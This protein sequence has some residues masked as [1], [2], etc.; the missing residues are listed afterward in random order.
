[1][2]QSYRPTPRSNYPKKSFLWLLCTLPLI[3][4]SCD[5]KNTAPELLPLTELSVA[6]N[7]PVSLNIYARDQEQDQLNFS[8]NFDPLPNV[9]TE[10]E[11]GRPTLTPL[12]AQQALFQ[13]VPSVGDVGVYNLTVS[14][15]DPGGLSDEETVRLEVYS[16][17]LSQSRIRFT[18]P[19]G[20]GERLNVNAHPCLELT[21][22]VSAEGIPD[23]DLLIDL[24]DPLIEGADFS[25]SGEWVGKSRQLRWCPTPPQLE[26]SDRYTLNLSVKQKRIS[27]SSN[28]EVM[29]TWTEG[30][31]KRYLV[32]LE[33]GGD[34][35]AEGCIGRPPSIDHTPPR[36]LE[37]LDDYR[38]EIFVS[39]DLGI[40]SP[41]LLALW[42][43]A[44]AP[45][46][47]L[48]DE[49]WSLSE[50]SRSSRGEGY[51]AFDIPNLNLLM[52]E[53]ATLYYAI[54]V[55][56][57][58]DA[59]GSR[60][61][62]VTESP[63][64]RLTVL[65]GSSGGNRAVCAPCSVS[66]QCGGEA[67]LCLAYE[68]GQFCGRACDT[69]RPCVSGQECL[70]LATS[71]GEE[72]AQCVPTTLSCVG[73]CSPDQY[74]QTE[75]VSY[76][77]APSLQE[78]RYTQLQICDQPYDLYQVAVP[79][80]RGLDISLSF[81]A[82]ELDL[83]LAVS[84]GQDASGQPDFA[85]ESATPDRS[86]ERVSLSCVDPQQPVNAL[87]AVL[88][89][90]DGAQGPYQL[91]INL[92]VDGCQTPCVDDQFEGATP[93]IEDGFYANLKLC[94]GDADR[95]SFEVMDGWVIS[96]LIEYPLENGA[97]HLTLLDPQGLPVIS[98]LSSR[99]EAI[100][101][102]RAEFGGRYTLEVRGE[103]Q[104]TQNEYTL[105]LYLFPTQ[106]CFETRDCPEQRFC[107]G[108]LGCLQDE[109]TPT[110][111]CGAGHRCIYSPFVTL[112]SPDVEGICGAEC[113]LNVDCRPWEQCKV[114]L[115]AQSICV[116]EGN[117]EV[118]ARCTY[119]DECARL[120]ACTPLDG[121][122]YCLHAA[123]E[124]IGCAPGEQCISTESGA[125]CLPS[126]SPACPSG[127]SC[128]NRDGMNICQPS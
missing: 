89:Y 91:E 64:Y 40:K 25:P 7:T 47:Q 106:A 12:S 36:Q 105:D 63:I 41:P 101:E 86:T 127:W 112:S 120:L 98:D 77:D 78:G 8:F 100:V 46:V 29:T 45:P 74:D 51:W 113:A 35:P 6:V 61:D 22:S 33:R 49:G 30:A 14:V 110:L 121:V 39:D 104:L 71:T 18:Q 3:I 102:W 67:D 15:R 62:H 123:C 109:C 2:A 50:F 9:Y 20:A 57:N 56:D 116:E 107:Y 76:A 69:S 80:G 26:A 65:S 43:Q 122:G 87:V 81:N 73:V 84:I 83:D 115:D 19:A 119:H 38:V 16:E 97:L 11:L 103:T 66:T 53:Q 21:I 28:G 125:V 68:E 79:A 23:E 114:L 93:L 27:T 10:G 55:T 1:M 70:T 48:S 42:T 59:Q 34:T 4:W 111:G 24:D 128:R 124:V 75:L 17:S 82:V 32:M 96:G 95:Y 92:P 60:C 58:D 52:G 44:S 118:G 88:P 99:A 85:F 37:G 108:Q 54:I 72:V 126:C 13:W 94:A 5:D 117:G 31:R 90:R